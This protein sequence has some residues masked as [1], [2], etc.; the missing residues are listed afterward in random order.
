MVPGLRKIAPQT[1]TAGILPVAVYAMIRP[2]LSSD[3]EGLVIIMAFPLAEI[4]F[5]SARTRRI[6][7]VGIIS[8]AGIVLGIATAL[9]LDGNPLL[10]EIR[11]SP[12]TVTFGAGCLLSLTVTRRPAMW[13]LARAFATEGDKHLQDAFDPLWDR[14]GL[15]GRF[16]LVTAIWGLVLLAEAA[17]QLRLAL[18]LPTGTF[19]AISLVVNLLALAGLITGTRAFLRVSQPLLAQKQQANS[20]HTQVGRRPPTRSSPASPATANGSRRQPRGDRSSDD[21]Y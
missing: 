20:S 3:A 15:P 8:L 4:A 9:A 11:T 6:E 13:H 21:T 7:P 10:L 5:G 19:L 17:T 14:P 18:T 2:H 12:I 1:L 16:K